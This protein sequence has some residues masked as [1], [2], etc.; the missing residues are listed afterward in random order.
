MVVLGRDMFFIFIGL[1]LLFWGF[2]VFRIYF[3]FVFCNYRRG[4]RGDVSFR[5]RVVFIVDV[6]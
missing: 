4:F 6:F 1:K 5:I 2:W 3:L